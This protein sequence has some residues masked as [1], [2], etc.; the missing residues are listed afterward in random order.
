MSGG[1][2]A[3]ELTINTNQFLNH[4]GVGKKAGGTAVEHRNAP[5]SQPRVFQQTL[6]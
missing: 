5:A 6:N 4:P 2:D 3:R 1:H